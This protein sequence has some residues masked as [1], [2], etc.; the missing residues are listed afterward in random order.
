MSW[1]RGASASR[2]FECASLLPFT[3]QVEENDKVGDV[4]GPMDELAALGIDGKTANAKSQ[5][6]VLF[7]LWA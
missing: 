6:L 7:V 5:R 4:D 3:G 1:F 2:S